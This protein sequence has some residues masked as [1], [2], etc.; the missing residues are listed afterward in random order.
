MRVI[1]NVTSRSSY[2][3]Q[4]YSQKPGTNG[5]HH[6]GPDYDSEDRGDTWDSQRIH[7]RLEDDE[8]SEISASAANVANDGKNPL[9]EFA[10]RYFRDGKEKFDQ[11]LSDPEGGQNG[12]LKHNKKAKAKKKKSGASDADWTWKDSVDIVKWTDRMITV[13]TFSEA[14]PGTSGLRVKLPL[15]VFTVTK[16]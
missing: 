3:E 13:S 2:R 15:F 16:T 1:T 11:V 5:H 14:E 6:M 7:P 8:L 12:S 10:M 9:L 4:Q